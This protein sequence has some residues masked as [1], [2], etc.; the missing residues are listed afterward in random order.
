MNNLKMKNKDR[1]FY[2]MTEKLYNANVICEILIL[3]SFLICLIFIVIDQPEEKYNIVTIQSLEVLSYN[4]ETN[5]VELQI[6]PNNPQKY[7]AVDDSNYQLLE[8]GKCYISVPLEKHEV[9]FID[10]DDTVS[11]SLFINH[12]VFDIGIKDI[13]YIPVHS[14][15]NLN[16]Y[17]VLGDPIIEWNSSSDNI[18]IENSILTGNSVGRTRVDMVVNGVI[19]KTF[20]VVVTNV[21]TEMKEFEDSKPFLSCMQFTSEEATLLDEI[22]AYRIKEAGEGTRAGAVAAARFLTLEFPYRISYYWENGRLDQSG[23]H[24]VDGEGRYYHKGLY[25]D[26]SKITNIVASFHGPAMWG[27]PIVSYEDDPPYFIPG[28]KYPNGLDCSGFVSWSLFNGGTDLGDI[29]SYMLPYKGNH[30]LLSTALIQSGQIKVGDLFSFNGH[31][32][33]LIGDDGSNFYVAESLND[34]GGIV[35]NKYSYNNVMNYFAAV[36]FM[37]DVYQGDGNLTNMWLD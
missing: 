33:I 31:V 1:H 36:T 10:E 14:K 28:R 21:I 37:D 26:Q 9:Y 15:I 34:Y 13:Y 27:C 11:D 20:E 30:Q 35:V 25:L 5:I 32:A 6:E 22:L 4:E 19:V 23:V 16:L 24:Y 8:D 29:G 2:F 18:T 7:C 3:F 12:Y 17:H